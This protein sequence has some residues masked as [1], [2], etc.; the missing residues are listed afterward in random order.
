MVLPDP[1]CGGSKE[2]DYS[3]GM[4]LGN[5]VTSSDPILRHIWGATNSYAFLESGVSI[6]PGLNIIQA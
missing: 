6:S 1:Y 2:W 4:F 5:T 3:V